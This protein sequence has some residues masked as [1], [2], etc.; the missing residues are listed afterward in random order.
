MQKIFRMNRPTMLYKRKISKM[1]NKRKMIS[2]HESF[3]F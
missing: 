1:K 3:D 2:S